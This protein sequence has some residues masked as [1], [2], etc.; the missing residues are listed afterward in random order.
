MATKLK[1]LSGSGKVLKNLDGDER[2][3]S[4]KDTKELFRLA[5]LANDEKG[6]RNLG[7]AVYN[8]VK[9]QNETPPEYV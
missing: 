2:I 7:K 3:F 8:M 6:L 1:Q 9:T 5:E 4:R